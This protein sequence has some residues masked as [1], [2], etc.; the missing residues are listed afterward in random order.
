MSKK[1]TSREKLKAACQEERPQKWKEHFKNLLGNP[2]KIT[3]K[4]I[5]KIING[6]R[7]I[8]LWQST[9]EELDIVLKKIK[10]RKAAGLN[11]IPSWSL[12]A[13]LSN[14]ATQSINKAK[15]RNG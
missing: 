13:Y 12:E 1:N 2:S 9:K 3:G 11:K 6:Q 8:W 7:D 15:L 4:P 10:I 14:Y 5:Q